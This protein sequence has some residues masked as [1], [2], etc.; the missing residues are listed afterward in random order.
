MNFGIDRFSKGWRNGDSARCL[1]YANQVKI[2]KSVDVGTEKKPIR[3]SVDR[4]VS[5]SIM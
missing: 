3:D 5:I 4:L 2:K 1:I